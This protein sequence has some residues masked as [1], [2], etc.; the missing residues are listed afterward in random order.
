MRNAAKFLYSVILVGVTAW[1][2][3]YFTRF[4]IDNWYSMLEKPA[5]TP[6]TG[7]NTMFAGYAWITLCS[8]I[9]ALVAYKKRTQE[10]K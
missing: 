2:C 4:G 1:L 5:G 8:G 7:D 9:V 3:S 10:T 6:N